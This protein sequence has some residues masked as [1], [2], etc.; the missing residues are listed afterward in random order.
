MHTDIF[1]EVWSPYTLIYK[2]LWYTLNVIAQGNTFSN[3]TS[4]E[5]LDLRSL[6]DI[7]HTVNMYIYT[8]KHED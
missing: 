6:R 8:R 5:P 4:S 3:Y 1:E 7:Q 2:E